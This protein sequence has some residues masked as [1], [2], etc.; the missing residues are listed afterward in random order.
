MNSPSS[1]F[2]TNWQSTNKDPCDG[3]VRMGWCEQGFSIEHNTRHTSAS[4]TVPP[5]PPFTVNVQWQYH[6]TPSVSVLQL[7]PPM[8]IFQTTHPR[9]YLD[10]WHLPA[11]PV[12]RIG[13]NFMSVT[14]YPYH[15]RSVVVLLPSAAMDHSITFLGSKIHYVHY[16]IPLHSPCP[17]P[18]Q[19]HS[20]TFQFLILVTDHRCRW[21]EVDCVGG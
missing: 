6:E 10:H 19:Q 5:P 4:V 7:P 21:A 17:L 20:T 9:I 12:C 2:R 18:P 13:I 14:L 16:A 11:R 8:I 3:D 1:T 15:L